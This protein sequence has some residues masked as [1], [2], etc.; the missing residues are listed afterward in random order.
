MARRLVYPGFRA[1][2]AK[3]VMYLTWDNRRETGVPNAAPL[4]T[5]AIRE[6]VRGLGRRR[7]RPP[8]RERQSRQPHTHAHTYIRRNH[9]VARWFSSLFAPWKRAPRFL[10][11]T[12]VA[13]KEINQSAPPLGSPSEREDGTLRGR[14]KL[15]LGRIDRLYFRL[16]VGTRRYTTR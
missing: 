10:N 1:R 11:V 8:S 16:R 3:L 12:M 5:P 2:V 9:C 14:K 15:L 6:T 13:D 7:E 4:S